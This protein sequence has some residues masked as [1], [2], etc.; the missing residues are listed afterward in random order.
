VQVTCEGARAY[1]RWSGKKLPDWP[2]WMIAACET[3]DRRYPWGNEWDP[4][5]CV[6][7]QNSTGPAPVGSKP[8]GASPCGALDMAGNVQ[9]W[10]TLPREMQHREAGVSWVDRALAG[11]GWEGDSA[12][13]VD[14]AFGSL[15]SAE[16]MAYCSVCRYGSGFRCEV[17]A[18][19]VERLRRK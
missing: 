13:D 9:E 17:S 2:Q 18:K 6:C 8:S 7:R 11:S 16:H 5:R 10:V 4:S 12:G 15:A 1:C 3:M 14:Q 19:E